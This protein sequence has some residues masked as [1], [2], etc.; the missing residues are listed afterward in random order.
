MALL[1]LGRESLAPRSAI[2]A[3]M[4]DPTPPEMRDWGLV[5]SAELDR[6]V[7]ISPTLMMQ[8]WAV[9]TL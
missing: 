6:V 8:F 1:D 3:V 5:G 4:A 7:V 9:R 2:L